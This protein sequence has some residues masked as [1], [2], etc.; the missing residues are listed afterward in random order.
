MN[1]LQHANRIAYSP[2][3][4]FLANIDQDWATL[5]AAIGPYPLPTQSDREPYEALIRAVAHQ[6][7]HGK[8]AENILGRFIACFPNTPFPSASE[9][10]AL[11]ID[12]LRACGFSNSKAVA[13]LGIAEQTIEGIVPTRTHAETLSNQE[14]IKRLTTLRGIGR[15]TVEMFLMHTLHQPDILPVDDFGV[16][17]G[18][19]IIKSLETQ[20]K[21]KQFAEIG[22]D[23][24]P[25]R[26]TASW[27]LWRAVDQAKLKK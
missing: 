13:I 24:S 17:E 25:F 12:Q 18:W 11:S 22:K 21:P 14:L 9:V 19:R 23:W 7:L 1:V 3:E 5:I 8:A 27:Y 26:S 2:A 16:R 6:Q 15:W 4:Q 10:N 20:P